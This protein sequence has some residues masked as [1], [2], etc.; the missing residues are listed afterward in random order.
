MGNNKKTDMRDDPAAALGKPPAGPNI[1]D[2]LDCLAAS[3]VVPQRSA[4]RQATIRR[5]VSR[6][7][8]AVARNNLLAMLR[9]YSP[10][11]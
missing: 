2:L 6:P 9:Q 7:L 11:L 1:E 10:S 8:Q 5:R 4:E 3:L